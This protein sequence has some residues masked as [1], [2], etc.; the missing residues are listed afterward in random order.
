MLTLNWV[1]SVIA[2]N[3]SVMLRSQDWSHVYIFLLVLNASSLYFECVFACF[4]VFIDVLNVLYVVLY[5]NFAFDVSSPA[6]VFSILKEHR[7]SSPFMHFVIVYCSF[8]CFLCVCVCVI[9]T[10]QNL[11]CSKDWMFL[12]FQFCLKLGANFVD[13]LIHFWFYFSFL[14]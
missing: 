9:L 14:K 4:K 2:Q 8:T 12:H 7:L 13:Q 10:L 5:A 1:K 11:F 3:V 6:L